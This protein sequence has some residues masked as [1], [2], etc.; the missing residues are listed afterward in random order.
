[1]EQRAAPLRRPTMKDLWMALEERTRTWDAL[2]RQGLADSVWRDYVSV[3]FRRT[4]D[5]RALEYLYP[6]LNHAD[7]ETRRHAIDA[8]ATVFE[9]RGAGFINALGYFTTNPDL[10]LRDRAVIVV[11]AAVTGSRDEVILEALTPY[12][13]SPNLFVRKL[14]LVALGKAAAGQASARVLAQIRRVGQL[15]GPREDEVRLAIATA[16][17]GRPTEEVW[18]L[19][20]GPQQQEKTDRDAGATAVLAR[21]ASE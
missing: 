14:A 6:Y 19:V 21:G 7:Q 10:F 5:P 2:R 20:A 9:G 12:L 1:M 13:N 18:S 15:P 8:A 4:G 17:A 16:F 3:R 11:G